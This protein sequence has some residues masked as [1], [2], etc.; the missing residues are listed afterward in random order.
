[1]RKW[2][3]P[4]LLGGIIIFSSV[5]VGFTSHF[6]FLARSG[7][8][9]SQAFFRNM[10]ALGALVFVNACSQVRAAFL[11]ANTQPSSTVHRIW[12]SIGRLNQMLE[13]LLLNAWTLTVNVGP[14]W[15]SAAI[16]GECSGDNHSQVCNE[17]LSCL[18]FMIA[19][20]IL[21]LVDWS[22][23]DQQ[24]WR[25]EFVEWIRQTRQRR[26][27]AIRMES[28]ELS[29]APQPLLSRSSFPDNSAPADSNPIHNALSTGSA[30]SGWAVPTPSP[31]HPGTTKPS[32]Q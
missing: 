29:L 15:T 3:Q 19:T 7:G 12:Q 21:L 8:Y 10:I 9:G 18:V 25:Q 31:S 32:K 20:W 17:W 23:S 4:I 2:I 27:A 24:R 30:P 28:F 14:R 16:I 26:P 1:M 11:E 22:L 5:V 6:E 13:I